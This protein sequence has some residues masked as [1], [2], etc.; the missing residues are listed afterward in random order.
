MP[1]QGFPREGFGCRRV[2]R[3][4]MI[5][6]EAMGVAELLTADPLTRGRAVACQVLTKSMVL[7]SG[8]EG[9]A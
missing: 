4:S 9:A 1:S 8:A 2:G 5:T 7:G 3:E 6:L